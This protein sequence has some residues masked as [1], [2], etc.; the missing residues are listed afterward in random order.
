M[1]NPGALDASDATQ[2]RQPRQSRLVK[3]ALGCARHG[4]FDVTLRNI[5][6]TGIG[7]QAPHVLNLGERLTVYLP[8]HE[9]MMGIVRWVVDRRF[10]IETE[11]RIE[12]SRLRAAHADQ[13]VA[14]D[15]SIAFQIVPPPKVNV[16]RPGLTIT[17]SA[18]EYRSRNQTKDS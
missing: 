5:S 12:P 9:P 2:K 11:G 1:P 4:R 16:W 18:P 17:S 13:I 6:E 8:G 3:A 15:S 7:G 14:A 10:G